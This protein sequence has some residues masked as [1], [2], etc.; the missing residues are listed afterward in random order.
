[1]WPYT[2][3]HSARALGGGEPHRYG[4]TTSGVEVERVAAESAEYNGAF[5]DVWGS[6]RASF[7]LFTIYARVRHTSMCVCVCV[8]VTPLIT[9]ESDRLRMC[10]D[11]GSKIPLEM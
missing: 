8:Q 9:V 11:H 4:N 1:M 10:R 3:V 7:R 5:V 2:F 6:G